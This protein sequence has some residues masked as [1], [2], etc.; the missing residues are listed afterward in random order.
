DGLAN[1]VEDR[2]MLE[3]VQRHSLEE[4]PRHLVDLANERGGDDNITVIAVRMNP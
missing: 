1:M 2:E 3:V 4:V